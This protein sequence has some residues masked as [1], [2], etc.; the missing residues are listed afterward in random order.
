M[1]HKWTAAFLFPFFFSNSH[2]QDIHTYTHNHFYPCHSSLAPYILHPRLPPFEELP[3]RRVSLCWTW[4]RRA[5]SRRRG[6]APPPC[7]RP[8]P[9]W[10]LKGEK[11]ITNTAKNDQLFIMMFFRGKNLNL[12]WRCNG[13]SRDCINWNGIAQTGHGAG[14]LDRRQDWQ[15]HYYHHYYC[16]TLTVTLHQITV[17][18]MSRVEMSRGVTILIHVVHYS[19][20]TNHVIII[21]TV[22]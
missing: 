6:S 11:A 10:W 3:L 18:I 9:P 17:F 12:W 20:I 19:V 1:P 2:T 7:R 8:W 16:I 5:P 4:P 13:A 14:E 21:S 22:Y 15:L